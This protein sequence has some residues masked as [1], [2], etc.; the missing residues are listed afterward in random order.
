MKGKLEQTDEEQDKKYSALDAGLARLQRKL[1]E[2][3][4]LDTGE[5][6]SNRVSALAEELFAGRRDATDDTSSARSSEMGHPKK[7]NS[8]GK[9]QHSIH[10]FQDFGTL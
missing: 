8:I 7:K 6:G 10:T 2:G 1:R 5:R 3:S 9:K 4:T